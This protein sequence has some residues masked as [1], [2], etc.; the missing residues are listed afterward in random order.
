MKVLSIVGPSNAGKTTLIERIVPE[1]R[2]RGFR[3]LVIKHAM[4]LEVD[5]EGKDSWRIFESGAD[6]VVA[7]SGELFYRARLNDDLES[8]CKL[9][10]FY[11]LIITEGFSRDCRD[12]IVVLKEPEDLERYS[13]GKVLAVVSKRPIKGYRWFSL[14]DVGSLVDLIV[15]WLQS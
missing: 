3:V 13:C 5:R 1:L 12:R 10:D 8:I 9:F 7:S 4:S 2:K 15:N 6:V 14:H 11:D